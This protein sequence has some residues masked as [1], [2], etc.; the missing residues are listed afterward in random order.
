MNVIIS[1]MIWECNN[2]C[3][4]SWERLLTFGQLKTHWQLAS[5]FSTL[6]SLGLRNA[7]DV[8]YLINWYLTE[9]RPKRKEPKNV[10]SLLFYSRS[11]VGASEGEMEKNR[12][13]A[14]FLD[15]SFSKLKLSLFKLPFSDT[16]KWILSWPAD[17]SKSTAQ[18]QALRG[19]LCGLG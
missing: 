3:W 15:P 7:D 14:F 10:Q 1:V 2:C 9:F 12:L 18:F 4:Y 11:S 5:L 13:W 16:F 8:W 19:S 17:G 6:K